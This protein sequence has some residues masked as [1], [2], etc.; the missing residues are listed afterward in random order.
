MRNYL[1]GF[2]ILAACWA[3]GPTAASAAPAGHVP[4]YL[5]PFARSLESGTNVAVTVVTIT[6]VSGTVA[7][8]VS[9]DWRGDTGLTISATTVSTLG[10]PKPARGR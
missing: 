2:G 9:V 1:I 10:A 4:V 6:R 8:D 7:C 5:I 3:G